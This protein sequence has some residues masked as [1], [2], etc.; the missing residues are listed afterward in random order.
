M[1][2]IVVIGNSITGVKALETIRGLDAEGDLTIFAL[3]GFYPYRRDLF[4]DFFLNKIKESKIFYRQKEFYEQ[5]RINVI[6][7]RQIAR[8]NF[9]KK[10]ITTEEKDQIDFDFLVIADTNQMKFPDVKGTG[11]T[12]VFALRKLADLKKMIAILPFVETVVIETNSPQG[13]CM[14][15]AFKKKGKEVI[16]IFGMDE[17]TGTVIAQRLE[18]NGIR[19]ILDN[20]VA[21]ILGD[22]EVKAIRLKSGK[23]IA[24][25]MV[26]FTETPPDLRIF[27]DTELEIDQRILIDSFLQTNIEGV[28][29]FYPVGRFK[30]DRLNR[31]DIT[32]L[33]QIE[34]AGKTIAGN[35]AGQKLSFPIRQI[36]AELIDCV[37]QPNSADFCG[38]GE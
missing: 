35:I 34:E 16:V 38:I 11:K 27:A 15:D 29:A 17:P 31:S 12:G 21:E 30:D 23:V 2:K 14:A 24:G 8:V 26:I 18:E 19:V 22:A 3:D 7:E 9:K 25:E 33:A 4:A 32:S 13:L 6:L 37:Q 36:S 5:N 28:F 1:K 10:R 20:S